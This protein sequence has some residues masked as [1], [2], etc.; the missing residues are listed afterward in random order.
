MAGLGGVAGAAFGRRTA[1]VSRHAVLPIVSTS[2]GQIRGVTESGIH[3]FKGVRYGED[4]A[5]PGFREYAPYSEPE[6]YE[7]GEWTNRRGAALM[8]SLLAAA[9]R[10]AGQEASE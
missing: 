8:A 3:V 4:T 6:A 9:Q 7:F 10:L 2:A 5:A 1:V